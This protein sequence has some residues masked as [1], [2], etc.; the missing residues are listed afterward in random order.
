MDPYT[1]QEKY[2]KEYAFFKWK[3]QH[4]C[5]YNWHE[6]LIKMIL[7]PKRYTVPQ[8]L[9]TNSN[10][11]THWVSG[12]SVRDGGRA[13]SPKASF[14]LL[15][16]SSS[17]KEL[18]W[19][20]PLTGSIVSVSAGGDFLPS[21]EAWVVI[22]LSSRCSKDWWGYPGAVVVFAFSH[23]HIHFPSNCSGWL[24]IASLLNCHLRTLKTTVFI[25]I[26]PYSKKDKDSL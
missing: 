23:T 15:P 16:P 9:H 7:I 19:T 26:I 1:L 24:R 21:P 13:L 5:D 2:T 11:W 12:P 18:S 3:R 4:W 25:T 20:R 6:M 10:V 14:T 8:R 17:C 22:T